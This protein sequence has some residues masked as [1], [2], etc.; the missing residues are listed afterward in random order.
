MGQELGNS[1]TWWFWLGVPQES[2]KHTSAGAALSEGTTGP[3]ELLPGWP[4]TWLLST[5]A[6]MVLL[7]PPHCMVAGSL[8]ADRSHMS[9]MTDLRSDLLSRLSRGI[10]HEDPDTKREETAGRP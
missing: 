4:L 2:V 3:E 8:R 9:F 7:E 1:L 5:W 6:P 10:G